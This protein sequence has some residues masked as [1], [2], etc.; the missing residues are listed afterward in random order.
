MRNNARHVKLTA[1]RAELQRLDLGVDST[2]ID[3]IASAVSCFMIIVYYDYSLFHTSLQTHSFTQTMETISNAPA[4]ISFAPSS[5]RTSRRLR[6]S[7]MH[8]QPL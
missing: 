5:S 3:A 6:G 8:V 2:V 4:R 7:P 1:F